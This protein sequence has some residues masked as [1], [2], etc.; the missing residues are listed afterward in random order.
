MGWES[1]SQK[2]KLYSEWM[3][4]WRRAMKCDLCKHQAEE[5]SLLCETCSEMVRRLVAVDHR[6]K[7]RQACQAERLAKVSAGAHSTASSQG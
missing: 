3:R 2:L 7:D 6:L 1:I 4:S 5:G